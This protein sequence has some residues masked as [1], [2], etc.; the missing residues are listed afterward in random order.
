MNDCIHKERLE[1][2]L[3]LLHLKL[4]LMHLIDDYT[5][6][7]SDA[8]DSFCLNSQNNIPDCTK[9]FSDCTQYLVKHIHGSTEMQQRIA[10]KF[11]KLERQQSELQSDS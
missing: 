3:E 7:S 9:H 10:R 4:K 8:N 11:E 2:Q 5:S 1:I 6:N